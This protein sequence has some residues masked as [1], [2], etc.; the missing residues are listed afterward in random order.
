MEKTGRIFCNYK[1]QSTKN[2]DKNGKLTGTT[3][4]TTQFQRKQIS[5]LRPYL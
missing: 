1:R 5:E 3:Y 4:D 2:H